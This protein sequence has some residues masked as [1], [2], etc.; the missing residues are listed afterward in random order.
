[1]AI[2]ALLVSNK[3]LTGAGL[4]HGHW[5]MFMH[6]RINHMPT[7]FRRSGSRAVATTRSVDSC[8]FRCFGKLKDVH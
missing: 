2:P 6:C 7:F 8:R 4:L 3:M 5:Q 1:M